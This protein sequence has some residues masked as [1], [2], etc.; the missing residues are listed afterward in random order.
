MALHRGPSIGGLLERTGTPLTIRRKTG[1]LNPVTSTRDSAVELQVET[2][3]YLRRPT[4][5]SKQ[6]DPLSTTN[7]YYMVKA[8]PFRDAFVPKDADLVIDAQL[9]LEA[10]VLSVRPRVIKGELFAYQL[11][12]SGVAA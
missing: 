11:F 8:A 1:A 12:V 9:G 10:R 4:Q 5:V 6:G 3:G 7:A 2:V